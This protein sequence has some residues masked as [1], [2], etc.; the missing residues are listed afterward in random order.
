MIARWVIY[1]N[2]YPLISHYWLS[3]IQ[4]FQRTAHLYG[5]PR[6]TSKLS[7][8]I[9]PIRLTPKWSDI[10]WCNGGVDKDCRIIKVKFLRWRMCILV[11]IIPRLLLR[12]IIYSIRRNCFALFIK[13]LRRPAILAICNMKIFLVS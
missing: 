4:D 1:T 11:L 7:Q 3:R 13:F 12:K 9:Q 6:C 5:S 10:K 2:I 8:I